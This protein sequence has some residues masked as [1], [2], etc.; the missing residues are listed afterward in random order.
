MQ[1]LILFPELQVYLSG[2]KMFSFSWETFVHLCKMVASGLDN[3]KVIARPSESTILSLH[4]Q[5]TTKAKRCFM[6]IL[7]TYSACQCFDFR[8]RVFGLMSLAHQSSLEVDYTL[9][10]TQLFEQTFRAHRAQFAENLAEV[11]F[12]ALDVSSEL[13]KSFR[14]FPRLAIP[15]R[16]QECSLLVQSPERLAWSPDPKQILQHFSCDDEAIPEE[17]V[18]YTF[19]ATPLAAGP[20]VPRLLVVLKS[21]LRE[22]GSDLQSP[23]KKEIIDYTVA[24]TASVLRQADGSTD[25]FPMN[26]KQPLV[27]ARAFR[28]SHTIVPV[29]LVADTPV[30]D[31]IAICSAFG[32]QLSEQMPHCGGSAGRAAT[33]RSSLMRENEDSDDGDISMAIPMSK[34]I[35]I[36]VAAS[37]KIAD[38]G[39]LF[40]FRQ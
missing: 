4:R 9:S 6:D 17:D 23:K 26:I 35:T 11:L 38:R 28:E 19:S 2:A 29:P 34:A 37:W 20:D 40:Y 22:K 25:S 3:R 1:E 31:Y 27:G 39:C 24:G 33:A 10:R 18:R 7:R 15:V 12:T 8:D 5:R 30:E 32:F 14:E 36:L 16:I 13:E 21:R